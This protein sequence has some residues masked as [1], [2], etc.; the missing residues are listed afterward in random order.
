MALSSWIGIVIPCVTV[1]LFLLSYIFITKVLPNSLTTSISCPRTMAILV[2]AILIIYGLLLVASTTSFEIQIQS[3]LLEAE[4]F[5]YDF[6]QGSIKLWEKGS[7]L[8]SLL[9]IVFSGVWPLVKQLLTVYATSL[10]PQTE[11]SWL[12]VL[13]VT[14]K[15]AF[16]DVTIVAVVVTTISFELQIEGFEMFDGFIAAVPSNGACFTLLILILSRLFTSLL[17]HVFPPEVPIATQSALEEVPIAT[18]AALDIDNNS[19][20]EEAMDPTE[21]TE[22]GRLLCSRTPTTSFGCFLKSFGVVCAILAPF[23]VTIGA[24]LPFA[25]R[26]FQ[27]SLRKTSM[28][29]ASEAS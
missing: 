26:T 28:R 19:S 16:L 10:P 5:S 1:G 15:T 21:K 4:V 25:S 11:L 7:P 18:H 20:E 29:A 9:I 12:R 6:W 3:E 14:G 2:T 13:G 22:E 27:V 23:L 24:S 17:I 8:L